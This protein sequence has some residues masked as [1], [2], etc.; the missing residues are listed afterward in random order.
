MWRCEATGRLHLL[1]K[2]MQTMRDTAK[3]ERPIIV[4]GGW[5]AYT[6]TAPGG[7]FATWAR[8]HVA[9]N[10]TLTVFK[11]GRRGRGRKHFASQSA[12]SYSAPAI[13][14]ALLD[15]HG[16]RSGERSQ[17]LLKVDRLE[18]P[19]VFFSVE[20]SRPTHCFAAMMLNGSAANVVLHLP[21]LAN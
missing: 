7:D 15:A 18:R 5:L 8:P 19:Q 1:F 2:S 4:P 17:W 10:R 14:R 3:E 13:S 9:F 21:Q 11:R 20:H 6:Y 12:S 16:Q